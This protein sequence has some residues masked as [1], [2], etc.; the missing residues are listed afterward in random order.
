MSGL[1]AALALVIADP[2]ILGGQAQATSP[3]LGPE[4]IS[5]N[6]DTAERMT[7]PVSVDEA[8]PF[9][10]L[11]D[12]GSERTVVS[13]EVAGR[14][15]LAPGP[16]ARIVG[17][18]GVGQAET[19]QVNVLRFGKQVLSGLLVP[20]LEGRHIGADGI[21]GI[22]ALQHQRVVLD[23]AKATIAIHAATELYDTRSYEIVVRAR[24]RDGRLI[25]TNAIFDG[26]RTDV[27]IDTGSSGTV[28]NRALQRALR[29]RTVGAGAIASVTGQV[30][31][32]EFGIG[33]KL[34]IGK[35]SIGNVLVAFADAPAFR[36]LQLDRKPA[37]FLGM[38]E[39]RAFRRIAI[40]FPARKVSFD[41]PAR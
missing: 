24:R 12:T 6:T 36:E 26:I 35:L 30:L 7:V 16:Q 11:I 3:G 33:A 14:L 38:R 10:F 2:L 37:I 22:D 17:L 19:A 9:R 8:G 29:E 41:L 20:L 15:A 5:L 4:L 34:S 32:A 18:A 13:E 25:L 39:M 40:D 27:V 1:A 23:F 31:P 28:G 21:I